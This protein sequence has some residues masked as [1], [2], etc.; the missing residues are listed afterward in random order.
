MFVIITLCQT[1]AAQEWD[2]GY[3]INPPPFGY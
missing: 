3:V 2:G 1:L